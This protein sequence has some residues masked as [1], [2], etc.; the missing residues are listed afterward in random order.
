MGDWGSRVHEM[1]E[2]GNLGPKPTEQVLEPIYKILL[3]DTV[4]NI[5][6][7]ADVDVEKAGEKLDRD[8]VIITA[9]KYYSKYCT[10][11]GQC[12][13]PACSKIVELDGDIYHE[14]TY[15]Q[16]GRKIY[17]DRE[18]N[19]YLM[20]HEGDYT[21]E[22]RVTP[23]SDYNTIIK[24][25][26]PCPQVGG[27]FIPLDTA[28]NANSDYP[29]KIPSKSWSHCSNNCLKDVN[30]QFWQYNDEDE[31][32]QLI[33]DYDSIEAADGYTIGSRDCPGDSRAHQSTFG[34]C[35]NTFK[36][37]T[38]WIEDG[39]FFKKD[40]RVVAGTY[41]VLHIFVQVLFWSGNQSNHQ[42]F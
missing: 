31:D 19:N 4:R 7:D 11:M 25:T 3:T 35:P 1:W 16:E 34:Q 15:D 26:A 8:N 18:K 24:R 30:C 22:W 40:S 10:V 37:S 6:H 29:R 17:E 23:T 20:Y 12:D 41:T 38:M 27:Q 13:F 28:S 21:N 36:A 32:C 9:V 5:V 2:A 42:T 39:T 33:V 14:T